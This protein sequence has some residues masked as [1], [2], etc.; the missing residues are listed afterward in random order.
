MLLDLG[1]PTSLTLF[2]RKILTS[3]TLLNLEGEVQG[4]DGEVDGLG[5]H[6]AHLTQQVHDEAPLTP[7]QTGQQ[8][9]DP[10]TAVSCIHFPSILS[11]KVYIYF[12]LSYIYLLQS[13]E[14]IPYLNLQFFTKVFIK[15]NY[16]IGI[17]F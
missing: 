4:S 11:H 5:V 12:N 15:I 16:N 13:M 3:L 8:L 6:P 9:R 1:I 2:N 7:H 17:D 10:E 14:R